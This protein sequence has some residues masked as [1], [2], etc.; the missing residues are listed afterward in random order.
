MLSLRLLLVAGIAFPPAQLRAQAPT[1][2]DREVLY[3]SI[4]ELPAKLTNGGVTPHW[5][6]DG[7]SFWYTTREQGN[8]V[9]YQIDPTHN[10]R[11]V[12]PQ[13][14]QVP[15]RPNAQGRELLS[16]DGAWF[17][18]VDAWADSIKD[19]PG[20]NIYL[21]P[22]GGGARMTLTTS[23][24]RGYNWSY[25]DYF[26]TEAKWSPDSRRLA[27]LKIDYR[28]LD[29]I[30]IIHWLKPHTEVEW[31]SWRRPDGP[32]DTNELY[33]LDV[34]T[35]REIRVDT[36]SDPDRPIVILGWKDD[37]SE[38]YF[39]RMDREYK[40]L[41][42]MAAD[43]ATGRSRVVLTER[44]QTYVGGWEVGGSWRFRGFN[45][46][47]DGKRFLWDSERSGWNG[48]YLYSLDGALIR[49]LTPDSILVGGPY[50]TRGDVAAVDE[51][52]GWVY[53]SGHGDRRRPYDVQLYRVGLDGAHLTRLTDGTG[54]H[55][56]RFAPSKQCFI[57]MRTTVRDPLASVL[58]KADGSLLRPLE[59]GNVEA[60]TALKLRPR[61]EFVVKADDGK[62]DL[63][64][65]LYL[66]RDF[67]PG[68]KYPVI[69]FIYGGPANIGSSKT[70]GDNLGWSAEA[71]AQLGFVTFTV[72]A[73]G[74]PDRG[75]AF[76]EVAYHNIGRH[77]I[78]DHVAAL[79]QLAAA[80]PY[81]DLSRV[82]ITG[83][84]WGGYFTVR[85]M[86]QAPEVYAVGVAAGSQFEFLEHLPNVI[87][88]WLGQPAAHPE[89][90]R[91][92]SNYWLADQLKGK[93]LLVHGTSDANVPFSPF[94]RM[95]DAFIRAGKFFDM[96]VLPEA[97][98]HSSQYH[99][100]G[101]A[102]EVERRYLVEHLKP[103]P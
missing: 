29:S 97:S 102:R 2:A 10:T 72:D 63:Y 54:Q 66:P 33:L 11:T 71:M 98:H 3:R 92:A 25:D 86:L 13:A 70:F 96:L 79:H 6:P 100:P 46:L 55:Y 31:W 43:P 57:D 75:K 12:L 73:R 40:Q 4:L 76:Q 28:A 81:M 90:Y 38:L 8:T 56:V 87:T 15:L 48:L 84:S 53:F 23:G 77:E 36:G 5:M 94:M 80:R 49:R 78:T 61:E 14:P 67:D 93:L 20:F 27:A 69:D 59:S 50:G 24:I 7:S 42:V 44:S 30:P 89:E 17:A 85:A 74:T 16:P 64:G 95:T 101:Y 19:F 99:S 34:R 37:A 45:L 82:G 35:R 91:Y 51:G 65:V 103:G 32:Y 18:G 83:G 58:R 62:T 1:M 41:D 52:A 60:Y 22:S 47:D 9:T 68:R 26:E 21:R 88:P 39:A